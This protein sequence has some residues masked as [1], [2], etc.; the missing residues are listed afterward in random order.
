MTQEEINKI[1]SEKIIDLVIN[2]GYSK[3]K[4]TLEV[5]RAK[6]FGIDTMNRYYYPDKVYQPKT[7]N[8]MVAKCKS[9]GKEY[10][11]IYNSS[12]ALTTHLNK[13]GINFPNELNTKFK[14]NDYYYKTKGEIYW[15]ELYFDI[16]EVEKEDTKKCHYCNWETTDIDNRGGHYGKHLD[17]V[18]NI[19]IE[20]HLEEYPN[21]IEY[22]KV[23]KRKKEKEELF[24]N[25]DNYVECLICNEKYKQLPR[26]L[27]DKHGITSEEYRMKFGQ[28]TQVTSKTNN[29]LFVNETCVK[30]RNNM[31]DKSI[32]RRSKLEI[33]IFDFLKNYVIDLKESDAKFLSGTEIDMISHKNKIGIE[34][35]GLFYH[36][37]ELGKD[38]NYHL[39]KTNLMNEKDY[40]LIHI[41]EDEYLKNKKLVLNKLL[42]TFSLNIN[43]EVINENKIIIKEFKDHDLIY[44]FL[45]VYSLYNSNVKT[46]ISI[47]AFKDDELIV[48]LN[49]IKNNGKLYL[50]RIETNYNYDSKELIYNCFQYFLKNYSDKY[51]I[52]YS[53]IDLRWE[54]MKYNFISSLG[55]KPI[56]IKK[57][58][59]YYFKNNTRFEDNYFSDKILKENF[60]NSYTP[61]L[62]VQDIL[63]KEGF[64]K[65]WDCGRIIYEYNTEN[66]F[67]VKK[68][69]IRI[70]NDK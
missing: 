30:G 15:Y 18:H 4:A 27:K 62:L 33:E 1:D 69:F 64:K 59:S 35:N 26:H 2:H 43:K 28:S 8:K 63:K 48:L 50:N 65:I 7:G 49:F 22:F 58:R 21:D 34:F 39:D 68:E 5:G 37:E 44:N 16:I 3:T 23:E 11:D 67:E 9:T 56:S 60:P 25:K 52:I 19:T 6:K 14:K 41:F 29:D 47:G 54:N 57:P 24:E 32:S 61:Y 20:K 36:S 13:I 70:Y 66:L 31:K 40:Q 38:S 51:K 46:T 12:G 42:N 53:H 10:D 17:S 55:F 45:N